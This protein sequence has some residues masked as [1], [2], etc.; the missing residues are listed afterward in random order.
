MS[1]NSLKAVPSKPGK[2]PVHLKECDLGRRGFPDDPELR[3]RRRGDVRLPTAETRLRPGRSKP[4]GGLP[5]E[6][7][8]R[9]LGP[10]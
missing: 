1:P 6:G 10:F 7:V 5:G 2:D 4:R 9:V 8:P 3:R